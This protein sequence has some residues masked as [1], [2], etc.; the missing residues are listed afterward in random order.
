[1]YTDVR[2]GDVA[3]RG[4]LFPTYKYTDTCMM[5]SKYLIFWLLY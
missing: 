2:S 5:Q 3:C 4:N 1:M